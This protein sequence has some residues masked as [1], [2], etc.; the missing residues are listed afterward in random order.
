MK[1]LLIGFMFGYIIT[2]LATKYQNR[3]EYQTRYEGDKMIIEK[4]DGTTLYKGEHKDGKKHGR[5]KFD[6]KGY[7]YEGDF[8]EDE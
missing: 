7:I 1:N 2:D 8:F 5:G 3:S 6:G 4:R